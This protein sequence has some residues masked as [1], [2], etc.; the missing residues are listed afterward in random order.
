MHEQSTPGRVAGQPHTDLVLERLPNGEMAWLRVIRNA[1]DEPPQR[2]WLT[3]T[4]RRA[5]AMERLF[6]QCPT[7]A[8][9][10]RATETSLR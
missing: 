10:R 2:Y 7:V 9:V 6:G 8:Q 3:D 1:A 5:L 4:G